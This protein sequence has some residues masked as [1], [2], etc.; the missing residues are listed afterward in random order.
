MDLLHIPCSAIK[1]TLLL[2]ILINFKTLNIKFL[3]SLGWK[4]R[5][6][7]F[8]YCD[9]CQDQVKIKVQT[10]Y[11]SLAHNIC[12]VLCLFTNI[13]CAFIPYRISSLREERYFCSV[14]NNVFGIYRPENFN[15]CT[16][17]IVI[18][19]IVGVIGAGLGLTAMVLFVSFLI[20]LGH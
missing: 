2:Q 6:M 4:Y 8:A 9:L 3:F 1:A 14:C 16:P 17:E 15:Q 7:H 20:L 19:I 18:L 13:F 5:G 12:C 10:R 11:G